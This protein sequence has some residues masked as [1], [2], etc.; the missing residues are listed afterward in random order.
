MDAETVRLFE[1]VRDALAALDKGLLKPE[2]FLQRL[3]GLNA[4][5]ARLLK[6]AHTLH[7][8]EPFARLYRRRLL[9]DE[10]FLQATPLLREWAE[11]KAA[12]HRTRAVVLYDLARAELEIVCAQELQGK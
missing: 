5:A 9:V 10:L 11:T 3:Q 8:P 4:A 7:P 1:A 6:T 2:E 12:L